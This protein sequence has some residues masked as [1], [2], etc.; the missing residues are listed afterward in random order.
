MQVC[1]TT[2][3]REVGDYV[4]DLLT[5]P[6]SG[7]G[8]LC[9]S[10][11]CIHEHN[12][13]PDVM[14][15]DLEPHEIEE[16]QKIEGVIKISPL[17]GKPT[18]ST[19]RRLYKI[20]TPDVVFRN[21]SYTYADNIGRTSPSGATAGGINLGPSYQ[22]YATN[23]NP[24]YTQQPPS[25]TNNVMTSAFSVDCREVDIII[26]DTGVDPSCEDL[27][28]IFGEPLVQ[29]FDWTQVVDGLEP[30][31]FYIDDDPNSTTFG[32]KIDVP[33]YIVYKNEGGATG[34]DGGPLLFDNLANYYVDWIGHGTECASIAAGLKCGF[35]KNARIFAINCRDL[36]APFGFSLTTCLELVA[37]FL[38][39]KKNGWY[40]LS[41][42]TPTILSCSW[43]W[44]G[45][46]IAGGTYANLS[47]IGQF[48]SFTAGPVGIAS[49]R[50]IPFSAL[51]HGIDGG[52]NRDAYNNDG[53]LASSFGLGGIRIENN[54]V[55]AFPTSSARN[56]PLSIAINNLPA[57]NPTIDAYMR[58]FTENG[59][60]V[61][62]CAGNSNI[63][64]NQK[65][66]DLIP[67]LLFR[68]VALIN[69]VEVLGS[70]WAVLR[71]MVLDSTTQKYVDNATGL[72][73]GQNYSIT[74]GTPPKTTT[75]KYQGAGTTWR[76]YLSPDI[77]P[78][79]DT[80]SVNI[81]A[82]LKYN[83][84]NYPLIKVGCVSPLGNVDSPTNTF[85][86]GGYTRAFYDLL[87][88]QPSW[89]KL[90]RE[91]NSPPGVLDCCIAFTRNI[92]TLDWAFCT[93]PIHAQQTPIEL[94]LNLRLSTSLYQG[95]VAG[96]L[97]F[98]AVGVLYNDGIN[99][100]NLTYK[101]GL[102]FTA[103]IQTGPTTF[104]VSSAFN[105][106][107][108][109]YV[110]SPY[111]NFGPAVD[112][113]AVGSATW[114]GVSN[115]MVDPIATANSGGTRVFYSQSGGLSANKAMPYFKEGLFANNTSATPAL[116]TLATN[117][118]SHGGLY[119]GKYK[120]ANGTSSACPAVAGM[121][122]TFLAQYP[123][124]TP[125]EAKRWLESSSIKGKILTT[126]RTPYVSSLSGFNNT[127]PNFPGLFGV[128]FG[129]GVTSVNFGSMG[130]N[131]QLTM[132]DLVSSVF[133]NPPQ[134]W[135]SFPFYPNATFESGGQTH[136]RPRDYFS[137]TNYF[138]TSAF[139]DKFFTTDAQFATN[140]PRRY[141]TQIPSY[142]FAF[143]LAHGYLQNFFFQC[144]F[145]SD[146]NNRI[147]Q[148]HPLRTAVLSARGGTVDTGTAYASSIYFNQL[149][150]VTFGTRLQIVSPVTQFVSLSSSEYRIGNRSGSVTTPPL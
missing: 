42:S 68:E 71:Q 120:F 43:T 53:L 67:I 84:T 24:G 92:G 47:T 97:T 55:T 99:N 108:P 81:P 95:G 102:E 6:L 11:R 117:L 36:G 75:F 115:Q 123:R 28:N 109:P 41:P 118:T 30:F 90:M 136:L 76:N 34:P 113:Y 63:D 8:C 88:N 9:G 124:A 46:S 145:F 140:V 144:R 61:V 146:S 33:N 31:T 87:V 85:D 98:P 25:F 128:T 112:V 37:G 137:N 134:T 138:W 15:F 96:A 119:K 79:S 39:G 13:V 116:R 7:S 111:S 125:L 74:A 82:N 21:A 141:D 59:M 35:A 101:Y 150:A 91:P 80:L 54:L 100:R 143:P 62:V 78:E 106:I 65:T 1:I 131:H 32:Q 3:N 49:G 5:N 73:F 110:K 114:A 44:E 27:K 16:L 148:A 147:A 18:L 127:G 149:G 107:D 133:G 83:R 45:P 14:E 121:L 22:Y 48:Q 142:E 51:H 72:V 29:I 77:G 12:M 126:N 60:H 94:W 89:A 139:F 4:Y 38:L 2:T 132:L 64:L 93:H 86:S 69:G 58:I 10:K 70:S 105:I 130:Y 135:N 104:H 66:P 52:A 57:S 19:V 17:I 40:G 122:A 26:L 129:S 103:S 20:R 50:T 56:Q 23:H